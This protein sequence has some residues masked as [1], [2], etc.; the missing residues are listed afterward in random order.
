M[1]YRNRSCKNENNK[2]TPS[3]IRVFLSLLIFLTVTRHAASI[4]TMCTN[5]IK[6]EGRWIWHSLFT[7]SRRYYCVSGT[8]VAGGGGGGGQLPPNNAFSEFCRYIWKFVGTYKPTSIL[9]VSVPTKYLKYQQNIEGNSTFRMWKCEHF[10][11]SLA[12]T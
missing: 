2:N 7:S 6:K 9:H 5:M 1:L 3:R 4:F 11:S 8:S 12:Y 10:L